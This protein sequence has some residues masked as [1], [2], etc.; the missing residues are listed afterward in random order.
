MRSDAAFGAVEQGLLE[1]I[2]KLLSGDL[3]RRPVPDWWLEGC[4]AVVCVGGKP[5][6]YEYS[7]AKGLCEPQADTGWILLKADEELRRRHGFPLQPV[8][9]NAVPESLS[10]AQSEPPRE[11]ADCPERAGWSDPFPGVATPDEFALSF[12]EQRFSKTAEHDLPSL[13]NLRE[14]A[15]KIPLSYFQGRWPKEDG[16]R[17]EEVTVTIP[18]ENTYVYVALD[19]NR[20][21]IR[22]IALYAMPPAPSSEPKNAE[23]A[24]W[25]R[26]ISGVAMDAVARE[27]QEFV[28]KSGKHLD[29]RLLL[30]FMGLEFGVGVHDSRK[31]G[32]SWSVRGPAVPD[33][34]GLAAASDPSNYRI[35]KTL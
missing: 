27:L 2:G 15:M 12:Y 21:H 18:W 33:G 8:L 13:Y 29:A 17:G 28:D 32:F 5:R 1:T 31:G 22:C 35:L 26:D 23:T 25:G 7:K 20:A 30:V 10:E 3:E 14:M 6:L 34:Y 16:G 19:K 9:R 11:Y 24:A 4:L